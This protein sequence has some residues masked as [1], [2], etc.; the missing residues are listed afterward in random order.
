MYWHLAQ[1]LER[2]DSKNTVFIVH[3]HVHVGLHV[4]TALGVR[5]DVQ[6]SILDIQLK[7]RDSASSTSNFRNERNN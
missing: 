1:Y 7:T 2:S 3:V 4:G 5:I 6:V